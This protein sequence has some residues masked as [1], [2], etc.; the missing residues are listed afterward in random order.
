[1]VMG[2]LCDKPSPGWPPS[3]GG[4]QPQRVLGLGQQGLICPSMASLCRQSGEAQPG[5]GKHQ[6]WV[7]AQPG[8][9]SPWLAGLASFPGKA[10]SWG[11]GMGVGATM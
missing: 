2:A 4:P 5:L 11:A 7:Q 8:P 10:L 1:M 9:G 6:S 3:E